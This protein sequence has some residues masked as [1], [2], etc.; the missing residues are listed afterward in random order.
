MYIRAIRAARAGGPEVLELVEL[1]E[2]SPGP[3][4]L[5]VQV[6]AAGVNFI[7]TYRR[8]GV[9]PSPFPHVVGREGAGRVVGTGP[10]VSEFRAGQAVAWA[11]APGSY[12][13]RVVVRARD[14]LPV[15]EGVDLPTAAALPLQ[16]MTAHYLA[17]STFPVQPGQD[18]LVHA[19]AG[20]VGLLLTQLVTARGARVIATVSTPQKEQLAR[21]AGAAEV[22]RYTELPELATDLPAAVR[23]LTDGLGV[24]VVFDGVGKDTF[25]A[26]LA[27]LRRRGTLALFGGASGQVPPFNPQRLSAGGSLF[28]TRPTL[29]D[30]IADREELTWRAG[31][32]FEAVAGGQLKVRIGA[33]YPLAEAAAAHA[34][35]ESRRTTG[36]VLLVP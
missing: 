30:Y 2:P 26:S 6:E 34:A 12:A 5:V 29:G 11:E 32:L 19:A 18:V 13:E 24:H 4:E 28:L 31:E 25:D 35:L 9:Y 16:G 15:P 14:A 20:G 1:P 22:I 3:G 8:S 33:T 36:K 10:G 21:E 7:D 27:A 17:V 23:S